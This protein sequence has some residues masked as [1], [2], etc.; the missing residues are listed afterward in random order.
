MLRILRDETIITDKFGPVRLQAGQEI[1]PAE[2]ALDSVAVNSLIGRGLAEDLTPV[3]PIKPTPPPPPV[4][5]PET[6]K[7]PIKKTAPRKK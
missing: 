4:Y 1:S 5:E 3:K 7:Q 6:P 2:Y